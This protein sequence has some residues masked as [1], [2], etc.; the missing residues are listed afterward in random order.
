[1]EKIW[2]TIISNRKNPIY[3]PILLCLAGLSL[4]YRL[5]LSL[6]GYFTGSVVRVS[7]PV[8]SVGNITVGGTG[9]TP[10]VIMLAQY[11]LSSG[12]KVGIVVSGYKRKSSADIIGPGKE[13]AGMPTEEIGDELL[14]MAESLPEAIFTVTDKKN[15]AAI[16][17]EQKYSPEII[18]IDDGFQHQKLHRD[19]DIVLIEAGFDPAGEHLFPFGRL[20]EPAK[21]LNRADIVILTKCN[22][23]SPQEA[24]NRLT[25][26]TD[27]NIFETNFINKNIISK[28]ETIPVSEIK[29]KSVYFFAGV[30]RFDSLL[31]HSA[32]QISNLVASR[33]FPDHCAYGKYSILKIRNDI[34][35]Y[36]PDFIITT[37][38]DY[39]KLRAFDFGRPIYYLDLSIEFKNGQ[40]EFFGTID[41]TLSR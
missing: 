24:S 33:E 39:V 34:G 14:L 6:R 27:K 22:Y 41:N 32:G 2:Q 35:R 36:N 21:S 3:W 7:P 30:G 8:I 20:R 29:A 16:N 19:L 40:R 5:G 28:T 9:K 4:C 38:K 11:L 18:L 26:I 10:F 12:K 23:I 13:L 17:L 25:N 15:R 1:M 37:Y 31:K